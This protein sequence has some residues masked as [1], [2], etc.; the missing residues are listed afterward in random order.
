MKIYGKV[1]VYI[2]IIAAILQ[3]PSFAAEFSDV[4]KSHKN[5][6]A[7]SY[8][9]EK[10]IITGYDDGSFKPENL[11]TRAEMCVI[12]SRCEGYVKGSGTNF[13]NPLFSDVSKSYWAYDY[14]AYGYNKKIINGMGDGTFLPAGGVTYEQAVK[15]V[16][17]GAGLE[18]EAKKI[19]GAKWYTGYL[20]AAHRKGILN[21]VYVT[22]GESAKRAD[23]AQLV[24]NACTGG[25]FEVGKDKVSTE[26][27][28]ESEQKPEASQGDNFDSLLTNKT[29]E[30]GKK[31]IKKIVIDPG[32]NY[33][34]YDKGARN[35]DETIK[36]EIVT[37]QISDK[38]KNLLEERGFE[39]IITRKSETDSIANTSVTESLKARC[40]LANDAEA[41]LFVSVHCNTGG[42]KG[43]E[44]YCF[45][46]GGEG[47]KL[48]ALIE[49]KITKKT[50]LYSRGVK[51]ANFYVIKNTVMPSVLIE[52]GFIDN[53]EDAKLLS[54]EEGQ[55]KIALAVAEAV[56][57]YKSNFEKQ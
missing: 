2:L 25:Y 33:E 10:K 24:Y 54:S 44:V 20:E 47:E 6:D 14:I 56:E 50:G 16:V 35:A 29:D 49:D 3:I 30:S 27:K 5:Y 45:S 51:T 39:V 9:A 31:E 32:H 36:E 37:W 1:I 22:V 48:A 13:E 46:L 12:L 15:M 53:E 8:L 18:E 42:G 28:G 17:C 7:V 4:A 21:G 52:T 43:C 23:I 38:L 40:D 19:G 26:E 57:E 34:G 55:Q 41:D 11:V